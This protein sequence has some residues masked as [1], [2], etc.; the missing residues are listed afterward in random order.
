M[1]QAQIIKMLERHQVSPEV[2]EELEAIFSAY[3]SETVAQVAGTTYS[4]TMGLA[5]DETYVGDSDEDSSAT[6][7][8]TLVPQDECSS[9][10]T[11]QPPRASLPLLRVLQP[12]V[13]LRTASR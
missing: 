2:L 8:L 5:L 4:D 11:E 9:S 7:D 13:A 1:L 3:P 12:V 6:L 10:S